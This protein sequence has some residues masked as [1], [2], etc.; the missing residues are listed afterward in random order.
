MSMKRNESIGEGCKVGTLFA[1]HPKIG[2]LFTHLKLD[3]VRLFLSTGQRLCPEEHGYD[4]MKD[5]EIQG[6]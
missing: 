3:S 5:S 4:F 2:L 1:F 6:R